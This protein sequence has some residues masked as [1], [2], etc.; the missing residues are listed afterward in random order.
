M[1]AFLVLLCLA[2]AVRLARRPVLGWAALSG[3]ALGLGVL[4]LLYGS[5]VLAWPALIF[6]LFWRL[7]PP[8][9]PGGHSR[10]NSR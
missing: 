3:W 7:W 8:S 2:V 5:L 4:P 1:F 10:Q 9:L 6:G